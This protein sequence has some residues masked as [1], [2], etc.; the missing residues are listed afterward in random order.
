MKSKYLPLAML[1]LLFAACNN[2]Q[3]DKANNSADIPTAASANN[4]AAPVDTSAS[5]NSE[6]AETDAS[7]SAQ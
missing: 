3:V 2:S 5:A 6:S 1:S 7:T 4:Q